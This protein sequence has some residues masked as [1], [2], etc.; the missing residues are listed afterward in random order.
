[1]RLMLYYCNEI[2]KRFYLFCLFVILCVVNSQAQSWLRS[3]KGRVVDS[4]TLKPLPDATISVFS[5][6]DTMLLNFGFTTPNGNFTISTKSNDSVLIIISII[7]YNERTF[8]EP[9]LGDQWMFQEYGDIK[10]STLP[11]A[12]KGFT[13]RT[14]AIRM[15][16]DTIEINASRFKVLPGSDV[17][18]LFK[19]IPGFE[20]SV[21]GEV[22]VNGTA[23]NKIMVDGSDFFGNN[24]GMVS[25][26]LSADMIETVQVFE[27]KNED[28][29]P[30]EEA[31]KIINLKLKKGKR[32]GT[33]GDF[34]GGYGTTNRYESGIRLNNF[35]ND[36]KVSF[37]INS[38]NI[39]E[40]GF[41]FGFENWHQTLNAERN[42]GGNDDDFYWYSGNTNEG[43]INNKTSMGL[44]YF[45]EF[46]R[47]RKLSVNWFVNRNDY[48]S[49]S[50][51]NGIS[52]LNDSTQ[53]FNKDS[54]NTKGLVLGSKLEI[55]FSKEIDSTG[56]YDFG[57]S[58]YLSQNKNTIN[59]INEIKL[60]NTLLNKGITTVQN[61][62]NSANFEVNASYRRYLRKDKRYTFFVAGNYKLAD[63]KNQYF[64]FLQ[65]ESDTFN[66]HNQ[67]N[68]LSQEWLTK[69][70]M[71]MPLAKTIN[72]NVSADRWQISNNSEQR[73]IAALNQQSNN[74]EQIYSKKIDTLSVLFKNTQ[75]QSSVKTFLS[76][77]KK[78]FYN[79]AGVTFL[80]FNLQNTN[81]AGQILLNK[82][83]PKFLPFYSLSYYP[84]K[85]YIS[86]NASKTSV[87]PSITDLLPVLNIS[88]NYNRSIGNPNLS[89]TDNYS[90]RTY[91]SFYK[92][93]G[94]KYFYLGGSGTISNTAKIWVSRQTED[95]II[96]RSPE[97]AR[98][99]RM[100]NAWLNA[101]RKLS[102]VMNL[103]F[104]ISNNYSHNPM[105][106]NDQKAFGNNS[107]FSLSPGINFSKAD[108]LDLT[109]GMEWNYNT[110]TNTLNERSNYKQNIFSY[111]FDMRTI[112][113]FGTEINTS[114]NISDQ[115]NVPGIGKVVPVWN[116][117]IQQPLGKKN[118]YYLK[119]TAYDILKQ[120]TNISRTAMDNFVYISQSNRLQQYFML[121]LVYKIKKMGGEEAMDYVY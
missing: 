99:Y 121:T 31:S 1:M 29:S 22:K 16:G 11:I 38:N 89:P 37:I 47:R 23:V 77:R 109:F 65:N 98:D 30:K 42:G 19:K 90:A 49:I 117:Y 6:K 95:G 74:F 57:V 119:L 9:A 58:G 61:Q 52:A 59:G 32:N 17:A 70:Y 39:N 100:V 54:S 12:L 118:K 92:L 103:Q 10:L 45:N 87:F 14:S 56:E 67:R 25:K 64:Q 71:A 112:L 84:G 113:K 63:N 101:S 36:R 55:N 46:K 66:N 82:T 7:G 80:N 43:N 8:K 72:L 94:F 20:V 110:Y 83:Y 27:E 114:L 35:K 93:K 86:F 50:A 91:A 15:K 26:N 105:V 28:G 5:A 116:A 18:Q 13:V 51:S 79:Q 111:N 106:I 75:V 62:N 60:N 115:R 96:V 81:D 34:L 78:Y 4:S 48:S 88:N 85:S 108:S 3:F 76:M 44:T 102:K 2:M 41:D 68:V 104:G 21:K 33:F 73:T 69:L 24:P 107:S 40:T 53:R 97:N 120:N